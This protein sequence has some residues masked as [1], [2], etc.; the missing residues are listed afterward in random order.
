MNRSTV[1]EPGNQTSS[2]RNK[3][4]AD[5]CVAG[6]TTRILYTPD[7]YVKAGFEIMTTI[8]SSSAQNEAEVKTCKKKGECGNKS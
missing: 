2:E 3:H 1:Y 4:V 8:E 5:E 7:S 6:V